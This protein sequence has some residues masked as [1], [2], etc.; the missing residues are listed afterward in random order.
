MGFTTSVLLGLAGLFRAGHGSSAQ[1]PRSTLTGQARSIAND[2]P[3]TA[4]FGPLGH[5]DLYR[6][7]HRGPRA[8]PLPRA[9]DRRHPVSAMVRRAPLGHRTGSGATCSRG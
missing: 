3:L 1:A 8:R 2:M 7:R 9:R 6:G 4:A 5:R